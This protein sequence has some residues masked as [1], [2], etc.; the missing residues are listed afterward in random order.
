[1]KNKDI[2]VA[3]IDN[4]M[5]KD[6]YNPV[7]HWSSF[8]KVEWSSFRAKYSD[9]PKDVEK[10]FTHILLTG[11]EASIMDRPDW[12]FEEVEFVKKAVS[13][14]IPI[15]GSCYGHQM[16]A[17]ALKG[18]QCVRRSFTPEIG[19]I[20][21]EIIKNNDLLSPKGVFYAYSIHFDEVFGLGDDF[22]V[23]ASTELCSVH[24]FQKKSSPVWGI[25][26]HPEI[27]PEQG[28]TLLKKLIQQERGPVDIYKK[29]LNSVPR[30]S[31]IIESIVDTFINY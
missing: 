30:D 19:W 11:S 14:N 2:K 27:S 25:Q 1:M 20:P 7:D 8:L 12:V 9:F 18:P 23:L 24:A 22:D 15:L 10:R 13:Q 16:V 3:I 31:G 4:S 26:S 29:A 5:E 28:K 21:I 6:I 17:L